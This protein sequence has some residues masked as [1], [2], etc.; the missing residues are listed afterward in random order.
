MIIVDET[1]Q[2]N[3]QTIAS[4]SDSGFQEQMR[5]CEFAYL[6]SLGMVAYELTQVH[7][8]AADLLRK[9]DIDPIEL[10]NHPKNGTDVFYRLRN[11][12][13]DWGIYIPE[14]D[15]AMIRFHQTM[16]LMKMIATRSKWIVPAVEE[17][18]A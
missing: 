3:S 13:L 18:G 6:Q 2:S 14:H 8:V 7:S 12:Y 17:V 16:T 9:A 15:V 4:D 5:Q 1:R 10:T 11:A